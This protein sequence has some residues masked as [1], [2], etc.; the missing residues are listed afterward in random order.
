MKILAESDK[1]DIIRSHQ[2]GSSIR[3]YQIR[4]ILSDLIRLETSFQILSNYR[5]LLPDLMRSNLLSVLIRLEIFY[6]ILPD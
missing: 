1:V 5:Y 2:I 6:Q 3:Y 4:D